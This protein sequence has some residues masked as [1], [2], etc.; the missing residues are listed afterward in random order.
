MD[1]TPE[2]RLRLL[3]IEPGQVRISKDQIPSFDEHSARL[4]FLRY[5]LMDRVKA[6]GQSVAWEEGL[7]ESAYDHSELDMLEFFHQRL[8]RGHGADMLRVIF[9]HAENF[10]VAPDTITSDMVDAY[11]R[12]T[13]STFRDFDVMVKGTSV[14]TSNALIR[15]LL[16]RP[17]IAV[18]ITSFLD[19]RGHQPEALLEHIAS[20]QSAPT[21][22]LRGSL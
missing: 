5:E 11:A 8:Q 3:N 18:H 1:I 20:I 16:T 9:I 14:E 22:L 2:A 10:G 6:Q 13:S 21:P 15:E 12:M 17:E 7:I 19:E 4:N